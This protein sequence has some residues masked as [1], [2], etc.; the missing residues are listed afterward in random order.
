[1]WPKKH[2]QK[3]YGGSFIYLGGSLLFGDNMRYSNE[4]LISELQRFVEENERPPTKREFDTANG[5][6]S[7]SVY[8]K[9]FGSWGAALVAAGITGTQ[10]YLTSDGV[11]RLKVNQRN[12]VQ[13]NQREPQDRNSPEYR[14]WRAAVIERDGVC[15]GCGSNEDLCAH[16]ILPWRY[17]KEKA[18]D[19]DNGMTLCGECHL[20][21]HCR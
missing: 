15:Q 9:R 5:Y 17:F 8:K 4:F 10:T 19:V 12:G 14:A 16:H 7:L 20:K 6:P 3:N 2:G 21:V 1:V 11:R 13:C 18:V